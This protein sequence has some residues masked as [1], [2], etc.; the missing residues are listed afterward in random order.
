MENS[1]KTYSDGSTENVDLLT[2][3]LV[4][5]FPRFELHEIEE[6]GFSDFALTVIWAVEQ[7]FNNPEYV[8]CEQGW[9]SYDQ[10]YEEDHAEK[11]CVSAAGSFMIHFMENEDYLRKNNSM[12][13]MDF[14]AWSWD[15]FPAIEDMARGNLQLAFA[16]WDATFSR[17]YGDP[18]GHNYPQLLDEHLEGEDVEVFPYWKD[19]AQWKKDMLNVDRTVRDIE[20]DVYELAQNL[21][22]Y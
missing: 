9:A 19:F 1:T 10:C 21:L 11:F 5:G 2:E 3:E 7:S 14:P 18:G 20:G 6:Q 4:P 12:S 8:F 15:F 13:L 22:F 17:E 16:G